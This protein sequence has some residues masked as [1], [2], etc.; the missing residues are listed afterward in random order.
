M[1]FW[2]INFTQER[3]LIRANKNFKDEDICLVSYFLI[4][5]SV[6]IKKKNGELAWNG[7]PKLI[8]RTFVDPQNNIPAEKS[9]SIKHCDS[10]FSSAK[11]KTTNV[12]ELQ[13]SRAHSLFSDLL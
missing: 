3:I 7:I 13:V 1:F 4:N 10:L 2:L 11:S 5:L 12:N 8:F 6:D 9:C